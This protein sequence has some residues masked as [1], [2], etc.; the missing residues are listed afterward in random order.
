MTE[1]KKGFWYLPEGENGRKFDTSSP[2]Y[3][4]QMWTVLSIAMMVCI[5]GGLILGL[6][7][8]QTEQSFQEY[9]PEQLQALKDQAARQAIQ[10]RNRHELL[11]QRR[12]ARN[13]A[14]NDETK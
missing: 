10:R 6:R 11:R 7:I 13:K 9:T 12:E 5:I 3:R 14:A 1:K 2:E 8:A 4:R